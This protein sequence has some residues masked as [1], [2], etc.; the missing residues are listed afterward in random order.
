MTW[1]S[2][3]LY[4][5]QYFWISILI[6]TILNVFLSYTCINIIKSERRATERYRGKIN[7][8][9]KYFMD[10]SQNDLFKEVIKNGGEFGMKTNPPNI[11]KLGF[12]D[13]FFI[14]KWATALFVINFIRLVGSVSFVVFIIAVINIL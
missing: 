6:I 7:H 1:L 9:R 4:K 8:I 2:K 5:P 10:N 13:I 11:K 14:G 3:L 12:F